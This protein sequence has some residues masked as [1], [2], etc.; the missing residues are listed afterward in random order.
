MGHVALPA[1]NVGEPFV[2]AEDIVDVAVAA[3]IDARHANQLYELTGPRLLTFEEPVG[4]I[5]KA[6]DRPI[7]Y[8]QLSMEEYTRALTECGVPKE[9]VVLLTYLF[10][11][12]L[13]GR[14]ASLTDGVQRALGRKPTD[15]AAYARNTAA[16]GIWDKRLLNKES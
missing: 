2:D 10:T 7:R 16:T 6:E 9:Y 11:E 3:L 13:D 5:A 15:F 8:E 12:V 14:N 1:G 4:E